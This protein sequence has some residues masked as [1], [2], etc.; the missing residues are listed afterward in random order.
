MWSVAHAHDVDIDEILKANPQLNINTIK[1]GDRVFLPKVDQIR[2]V[3]KKKLDT[4]QWISTKPAV[5]SKS[6]RKKKEKPIRQKVDDDKIYNF[7]W[8]YKGSVIST[9]GMRNQ[10]MH[11]GIDIQIP[12]DQSIRASY[13]GKVVYAGDDI[14][15]YDR[16][17]IVLHDNHFFTIYA[18]LGDILVQKN[19]MI[20]AGEAIA[21]P[22]NISPSYF[23]FEIRYIKTALDPQRYLK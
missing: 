18:Y 7:Q 21:K 12:R 4:E 19:Q 6:N 5:A 15:G 8:P 22:Q 2:K 9:F 3:P 16:I 11:N 14:E 23:H 17:V 13:D 1:P 10:K 20:K